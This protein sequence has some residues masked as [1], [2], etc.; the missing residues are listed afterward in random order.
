MAR[1][2]ARLEFVAKQIQRF[3]VWTNKGDASAFTAPAKFGVF[4]QE[5]IARV[6][7]IAATGACQTNNFCAVQIPLNAGQGQGHKIISVAHMGAVAI[8]FGIDRDTA[9]SQLL[10]SSSDANRNLT[11]VGDKQ[12]ANRLCGVGVCWRDVLW[13]DPSPGNC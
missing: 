7:G 9:N 4:C 1:Q 3:R 2:L 10:G 6:D 8:V 12:R 5:A 13:H 11:P